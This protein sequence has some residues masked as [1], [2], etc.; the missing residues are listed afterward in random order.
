MPRISRDASVSWTGSLSRGSGV[1][2]AASSGAF[3]LPVTLGSRIG[4]PEGK[5]SPEELLAAAHASC[6]VTSLAGESARAGGTV[7]RLD[8]TCTVTMDEVEGKGHQIVASELE[9]TCRV[10]GLDED[11]FARAAEAADEGC[12]FSALLRA[13]ASVRVRAQLESS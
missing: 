6:F 4:E 12:P 10:E 1:V 2:S 3:E 8:V 7:E 9:A 13:S 5:T 11:A